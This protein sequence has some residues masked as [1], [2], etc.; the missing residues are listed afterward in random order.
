[1]RFVR[2]I[3]I[4][5]LDV[6]IKT[7]KVKPVKGRRDCLYFFPAEGE[8]CDGW[9]TEFHTVEYRYEYVSG[10]VSDYY[11]DDRRICI[12]LNLDIEKTGLEQVV[13][14]YADPEGSFWD[15]IGVVEYHSKKG[16]EIEDVVSVDIFQQK[17]AMS[18]L[19]LEKHFD[20]LL[21]CK[22]WLSEIGIMIE[23]GKI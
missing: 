2:F 11:I 1:M 7:G 8:M 14:T 21:E 19:S 16:Y 12:V 4:E 18:F 23:K 10:I 3:G 20:N 13:E 6:L 9:G 17:L 15:T 22:K 5:E